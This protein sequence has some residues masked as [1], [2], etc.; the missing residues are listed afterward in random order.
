MKRNREE[1]GTKCLLH[2]LRVLIELDLLRGLNRI[3]M[4]ICQ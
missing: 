1:A 4:E 2:V 3:Y